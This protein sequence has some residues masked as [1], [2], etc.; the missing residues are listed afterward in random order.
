LKPDDE[1]AALRRGG[2]DVVSDN[3]VNSITL[4]CAA[5][6]SGT[7]SVYATRPLSCRKYK[8]E[9]L[10]RFEAKEVSQ[11]VTV[12]IVKNIICLKDE[13][14]EL[15]GG[16]L[17][18]MAADKSIAVLM[19]TKPSIAVTKPGYADLFFK[20]GALEIYLDRFFRKKLNTKDITPASANGSSSKSSD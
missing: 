6:K 14:K 7:C 19:K 15:A 20:L 9:L 5:L 12:N 4:P 10:K 17:A 3:K 13:V 2:V 1:I 8:C 16:T 18:D 11:E